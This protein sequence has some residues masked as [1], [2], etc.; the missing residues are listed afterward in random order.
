M[1]IVSATVY[2]LQIPFTDG[3]EGTGLMPAR[4]THLQIALLKLETSDGM[5]GWGEAFAYAHLATT[6]SAL[7]ELVLPMVI[8]ETIDDISAFNRSLQQKTHLHGR[9]GITQFALSA[10]DMALWD[11]AAKQA[12]QSLAQ[13][14]CS[15]PNMQSGLQ[16]KIRVP[17]YA[18]L[19]RYGD[20]ECPYGSSA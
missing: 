5:T 20:P 11:I 10:V 7:N 19:V 13:F 1:K 15:L 2:S 3:G 17:A 16:P 9:Y 8:G 6:V 12:N 14:L 18:S 4:W